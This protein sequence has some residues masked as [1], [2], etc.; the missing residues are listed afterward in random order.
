MTDLDLKNARLKKL[1]VLD[2]DFDGNFDRYEV[3]FADGVIPAELKKLADDGA[4]IYGLPLS[5][6]DIPDDDIAVH[7]KAR[8]NGV[9]EIALYAPMD[10]QIRCISIYLDD[11]ASKV[12]KAKIKD[13]GKKSSAERE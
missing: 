3:Q 10:G 1:D 5:F 4:K 7:L 12:A 13:A 2:E 6:T 11:Y 8:P 9:T